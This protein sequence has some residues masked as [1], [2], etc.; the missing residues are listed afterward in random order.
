MVVLELLIFGGGGVKYTYLG[1]IGVSDVIK[2]SRFKNFE[3]LTLSLAL[4]AKKTYPF[5]GLDYNN[6][7]IVSYC[8]WPFLGHFRYNWGSV[9]SQRDQD[10]EILKF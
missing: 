3:I 9:T 7:F 6:I 1:T 2:G 4:L 5:K 10:F 8:L